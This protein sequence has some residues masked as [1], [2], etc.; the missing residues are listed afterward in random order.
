[1]CKWETGECL[2]ENAV[3]HVG[4]TSPSCGTTNAGGKAKP[5]CNLQTA[6]DRAGGTKTTILVNPG[7]YI[8]SIQ[9]KNKGSSIWIVGKDGA[10]IST[11]TKDQGNV[12]IEGDSKVTLE[13]LG[14]V[15]A[16]GAGVGIKCV[17]TTVTP[18]LTVRGCTITGNTG[19]GVSLGS[20]GFNMTSNVIAANGSGTSTF[21]GIWITSAGNNA[22][23]LNN[24]VANNVLQS[25]T[26][27]VA[28]I[29]CSAS[30]GSVD[31]R[32]TISYKNQ[33][34]DL[35][36]NLTP[37]F[38]CIYDGTNVTSGTSNLKSDDCA[39]DAD[40]S[41]K[42][43]DPKPP[44]IDAADPKTQYEFKYNVDVKGN[45]RVQNGRADIGAYEAG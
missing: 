35:S 14:I 41:L 22:I 1:V 30:C 13:H 36:Q 20:C 38:S 31:V 2:S 12:Y 37:Q 33:K 4:Q 27:G 28:G 8:E 3:I 16:P 43:T 18:M 26:E 40:Y 17:A 21:G 23:L 7:K 24:T 15:N 9:I 11:D 39:L 34:G 6:V 5:L 19:G 32:N 29:W 45:N 10:N 44:C 25:G 42:K